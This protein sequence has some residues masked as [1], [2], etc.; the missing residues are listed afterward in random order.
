MRVFV[1][2]R[3]TGSTESFHAVKSVEDAGKLRYHKAGRDIS[4]LIIE[5]ATGIH[6]RDFSDLETFKIVP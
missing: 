2:Y 4:G 6:R 5:T 1:T 3:K